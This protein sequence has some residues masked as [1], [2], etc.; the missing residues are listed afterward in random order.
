MACPWQMSVAEIQMVHLRTLS[1]RRQNWGSWKKGH[2]VH[3]TCKLGTTTEQ[4]S[5]TQ[6]AHQSEQLPKENHFKG[7]LLLIFSSLVFPVFLLYCHFCKHW[8][9]QAYFWKE[10]VGR[11]KTKRHTANCRAQKVCSSFCACQD[12]TNFCL[13]SCSFYKSR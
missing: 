4:R 11:C 8:K 5:H 3:C 7:L 6:A 10:Y 13:Y 12:R 2:T 1:R 9:H